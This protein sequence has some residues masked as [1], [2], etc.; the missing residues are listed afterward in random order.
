MV[1]KTVRDSLSVASPAWTFS[2]S[3]L[4]VAQ[5]HPA[6]IPHRCELLQDRR[7]VMI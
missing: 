4:R 2:M 5:D 1:F 6:Y 7:S 3:A